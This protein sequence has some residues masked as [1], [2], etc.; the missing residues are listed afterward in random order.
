MVLEDGSVLGG[1]NGFENLSESRGAIAVRINGLWGIIDRSGTFTVEP[2]F[3]S[4]RADRNRTFAV[5]EGEGVYWINAAGERVAK[6]A[7]ERVDPK[8]ALICD[9]G[10]RYFQKADLWGLQNDKGETVIEPRFRALSCFSQGVSWTTAPGEHG[11]CPIGLD[12]RR[13]EVLACREIFYLME[14]SDSDPEHF[15]HDPF[16]NSVLWS[17]AWLDYQAGNRE[18]EPKWSSAR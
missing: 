14:L 2:H 6:P 9:G 13:S 1:K 8:R 7:T 15:S 12:G 18:T 3:A 11:W 16:E 10:L 5:G 4:L 17:R